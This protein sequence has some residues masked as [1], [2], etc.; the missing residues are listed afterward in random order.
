[1]NIPGERFSIEDLLASDDE[2]HDLPPAPPLENFIK[3]IIEQPTTS[4]P[5]APVAPSLSNKTGFPEHR[6]RIP[7]NASRFRQQREQTQQ[8]QQ[9]QQKTERQ[10][11]SDD[12]EARL[13]RMKPEEIE[14]ERRELLEKYSPGLIETLLKRARVEDPG[15]EIKRKGRTEVTRDV[16]KEEEENVVEEE[17]L[18]KEEEPRKVVGIRPDPIPKPYK[19]PTVTED[20]ANETYRDPTYDPDDAAPPV[21]DPALF[22]PKGSYHF[23]RAPQA[24]TETLDPTSP[25]FLQSLHTKYFPDLPSD[26]SKLAWMAPPSENEDLTYHPSQNELVPSALRFD[27]KGELLPPRKARELPGHLGLHHHADAPNAAGYTIPEL[28]RLARSTFPT[29]RCVAMQTLGRV[30]F[31]LGTGVYKNSEIENGLWRCIEEGRV[32]AGLEEAVNMKGG[33]LSVKAHATDAL[34]LWQKGGGKRMKAE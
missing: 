21:Y 28:A 16:V 29:Q 15:F 10:Q 24:D 13:A 1:M 31:K 25:D 23:P 5:T 17:T 3:D 2:D 34:W 26:P 27:F 32:L 8:P 19:R 20:D 11:I 22:P 18:G 4:A 6:K 14:E 9:P 33:H 12:N 30:M 7:K